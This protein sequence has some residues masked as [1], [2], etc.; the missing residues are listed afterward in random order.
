MKECT[1]SIAR[2]MSNPAFG[3][4]FFVGDGVDIGGRPDPLSLHIHLF[5]KMRSVRVW[6]L[7]DGDA[8]FMDGISEETFDFVH[9]SHC[10]EHL[11]DPLEGLKN[12][13]R[14]TKGGGHVIV[15]VPDEDMYE[16]GRFP[17][18][19]N[20]DHKHTFTILKRRSWSKAS[21]NVL[22]LVYA[23]G[24]EAELV[25]LNLLSTTFNYSLPRFDQTLTP[26]AEC[27]IE[28]ILRKR[29][30]HELKAFGRL[31]GNGGQ[32]AASIRTH[33]NQFKDDLQTLKKNNISNPPFE[34]EEFL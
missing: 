12:W 16:Q 10:L 3:L 26:V 25:A 21:I 30:A 4:E 31:G 33:L 15:T 14:V 1:K 27:G 32:P 5:P 29:D 23:L 20:K 24:D 18:D 19:F 7:E 17:S 22:D 9:S 13:M 2:R 8:Q 34:N 11:I 28:F 6:D